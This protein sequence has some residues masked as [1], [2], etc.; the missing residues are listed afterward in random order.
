LT[1]GGQ[2]LA[3]IGNF[4]VLMFI[5]AVLN[6][7]TMNKNVDEAALAV[8]IIVIAEAANSLVHLYSSPE[9]RKFLLEKTD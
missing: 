2:S 7:S 8:L 5:I 3:F 6:L 9:M 1:V 4:V